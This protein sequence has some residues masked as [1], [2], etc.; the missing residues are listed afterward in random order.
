L[1]RY[2][3]SDIMRR[4][5][6]SAQAIKRYLHTFGRVVMLTRKGLNSHEIAYAVGI[7]ERLTQQYL[8]LYRRCNIPVYQARLDEIVQMISGGAPV[9]CRAKRGH[10]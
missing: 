10:Q 8:A 9:A 4:T 3:Y 6:H 5:R 2:T 1:K 7:S